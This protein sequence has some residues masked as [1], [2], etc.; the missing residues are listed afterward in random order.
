MEPPRIDPNR[1][2]NR[3]SGGIKKSIQNAIDQHDTDESF[4]KGLAYASLAC[5]L[6]SVT[7]FWVT[8]VSAI[9]GSIGICCGFVAVQSLTKRKSGYSGLA[10]VGVILNGIALILVVGLVVLLRSLFS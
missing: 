1:M 9:L 7:M 8:F 6:I 2:Q 5:G 4:G 3:N 10:V